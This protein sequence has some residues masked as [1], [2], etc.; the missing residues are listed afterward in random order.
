MTADLRRARR[1]FL[2]VAVLGSALIALIGLTLVLLWLPGIPDPAAV[3]WTAN[4]PDGFAPRS[5]YVWLQLGA[6]LGLP[7]LLALFT[8]LGAKDSWGATPR[9]LGAL[10][11]ALAGFFAVASAGSVA[12]QRGL[13]DAAAAP[14]VE[15]TLGVAAGFAVVLG[16]AGWLLQPAVQVMP[17]L[18]HGDDR[19]RPLALRPGE[20]AAWVGTA[21]IARGGAVVLALLLAILV[22]VTVVLIA[23]GEEA[24]WITGVV[25]LFVALAMASSL[26][27]RVRV[28]PGGF[29]VRSLLGWPGVR[30]RVH[31]IADVQ[32]VQVAPLAEFGGWGW[33][34]SVA[35]GRRGAVLRTGEALQVTTTGGRSYVVTVY[36]AAQAAAV[37]Q[38]AMTQHD[39]RHGTDTAREDGPD[40]AGGKL[41]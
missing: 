8:L 6:G 22:A 28:G 11:L 32:C 10:A 27:F 30:L 34:I 23:V 3:H 14:G 41:S 39:A 1:A 9:L 24:W 12:L 33:R 5:A 4:G 13:D 20:R 26:T 29:Q 7:L 2:M 21:T 40:D 37:L 19:V 25:T 31:Q 16:V 17:R 36:G 35:D 15:P 38:A 18:S